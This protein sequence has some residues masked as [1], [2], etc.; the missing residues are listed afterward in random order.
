M[1]KTAKKKKTGLLTFFG[2]RPLSPSF[3]FG[4]ARDASATR[5]NKRILNKKLTLFEEIESLQAQRR[6]GDLVHN[7]H[8]TRE[9]DALLERQRKLRF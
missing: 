8:I 5:R 3:F 9:I 4:M 2:I 7:A 6:G 1:K